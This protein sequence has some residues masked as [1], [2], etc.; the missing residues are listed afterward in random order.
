[1]GKGEEELGTHG[2]RE[3]LCFFKCANEHIK[4]KHHHIKIT[5]RPSSPELY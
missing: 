4:Q 5:L 2:L 3:I 1:M